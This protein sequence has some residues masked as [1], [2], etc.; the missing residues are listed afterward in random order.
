MLDSGCSLVALYELGGQ[1]QGWE[2]IDLTRL[3]ESLVLV[4]KR[5]PKS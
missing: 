4:G 1:R 5:H 3:P 2:V